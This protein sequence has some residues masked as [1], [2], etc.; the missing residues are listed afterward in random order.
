MKTILCSL[1]FSLILVYSGNAQ[2]TDS[3]KVASSCAKLSFE[4]SFKP[5]PPDSLKY[6][7]KSDTLILEFKTAVANI[8]GK[9]IA[10]RKISNDTISVDFVE[11]SPIILPASCYA[12]LNVKMPA[13]FVS[14]NKLVLKLKGKFY[15]INKLPTEIQENQKQEEVLFFPNPTK[16]QVFINKNKYSRKTS[17]QVLLSETLWDKKFCKRQHPSLL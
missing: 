5:F 8:P 10:V 4:D 13:T 12:I 14:Q 17:I 2:T 9:Y 16:Y 1:L 7:P 15:N 11:T 3:L 6:T